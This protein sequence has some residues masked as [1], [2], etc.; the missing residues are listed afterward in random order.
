[1][2]V[3]VYPGSSTQ[4]PLPAKLQLFKNT[5]RR[6]ERYKPK[7][8]PAF[9]QATVTVDGY[10]FRCTGSR[11]STQLRRGV[12][13]GHRKTKRRRASRRRSRPGTARSRTRSSSA[14][15]LWTTSTRTS[16][17]PPNPCVRRVR[18]ARSWGAIR[19]LRASCSIGI[20][21]PVAERGACSAMQGGRA[22]PDGAV[23]LSRFQVGEPARAGPPPA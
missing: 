18:R 11:R 8:N 13:A 10:R 9:N 14:P 23:S 12:P 1:M 21:V 5:R 19:R 4:G 17:A 15:A 3:D 20:L 2:I 7:P 6:G 22:H 16:A